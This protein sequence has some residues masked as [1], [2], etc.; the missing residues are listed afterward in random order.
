MR[1]GE[2]DGASKKIAWEKRAYTYGEKEEEN[3]IGARRSHLTR[4]RTRLQERREGT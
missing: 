4:G 1:R 2:E 3:I